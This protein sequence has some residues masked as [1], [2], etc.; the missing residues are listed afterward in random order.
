M[1]GASPCTR[2]IERLSKIK[3]HIQQK[4]DRGRGGVGYFYSVINAKVSRIMRCAARWVPL[5]GECLCKHDT[6]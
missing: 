2:I 4:G 3:T 6:Q 1:T 5:K